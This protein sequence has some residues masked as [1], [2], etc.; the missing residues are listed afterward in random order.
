VVEA[1]VPDARRGEYVPRGCGVNALIGVE[2][3]CR[4]DETFS[5]RIFPIWSADDHGRVLHTYT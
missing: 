4:A 3:L 5:R 2:P 1:A